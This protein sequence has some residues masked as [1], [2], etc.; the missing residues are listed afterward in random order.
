MSCSALLPRCAVSKACVTP[1][2]RSARPSKTSGFSPRCPVPACTLRRGGCTATG[3]QFALG[4]CRVLGEAAGGA[5]FGADWPAHQL[6]V[7]VRTLAAQHIVHAVDA[8]RALIGAHI[9]IA[10][11]RRQI[12][13]AALAV[14]AK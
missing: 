5:G 13:V 9:R 12:A 11:L 10:R 8:E 4:G 7:A 1:A 6:A 14:R 2:G 3:L